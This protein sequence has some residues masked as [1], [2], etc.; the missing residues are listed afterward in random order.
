MTIENHKQKVIVI[1]GATA[2]GKSAFALNLAEKLGGT[3]IN[4]DS[5]QVYHD[6]QI[7]TA[8]PDLAKMP[9]PHKLYGFLNGIETCSAGIWAKLAAKEIANCFNENKLPIIVGGTGL[10]IESLTKGLSPIP[11][12]DYLIKEK[13]RKNNQD[14]AA[15]YEL[16]K[17]KDFETA[18]KLRSNDKQ[19]IVR[20][21]EVFE[22]TGKSLLLWQKEPLQKPI[23]AQ[24]VNIFI[25]PERSLLHQNI[26]Y[27]FDEMLKI[28]AIDEVKTLLEKKYPLS[29]PIM[30]ALGVKEITAYLRQEMSI[31][32]ASA[33]AKAATRQ[34]AK[35]QVTWFKNRFDSDF[36]VYNAKDKSEINNLFNCLTLAFSST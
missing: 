16:L 24:F 9:I 5:M 7:L 15:L 10:Y 28:G 27:R 34:Y 32:D 3:I 36:I 18:Q 21:L 6:L 14:T 35:R 12:T 29:T 1:Y 22:S 13:Y 25:N 30:K 23:N 31:E 2:S 19:R 26:N 20:A 4:A 17:Q 11:E 33:K 8:R